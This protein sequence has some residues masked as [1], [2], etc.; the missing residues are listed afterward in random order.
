MLRFR[1]QRHL[2]ANKIRFGQQRV[3]RHAARAVLRFGL[4]MRMPVRVEHV[5]PKPVRRTAGQCGADPTQPDDADRLAL[6]VRAVKLRPDAALPVTGP[7]PLG[8]LHDTTRRRENEREHGIGG[9]LGQHIRCVRQ[10]DAPTRE[11]GHIEIVIADGDRRP[12]L[13]AG[14]VVEHL[15]RDL[16][17]RTDRTLGLCKRLGQ[18]LGT[19]NLHEFDMLAQLSRDIFGQRLVGN[20]KRFHQFIFQAQGGRACT[21]HAV[22][23]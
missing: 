20:D 18:R 17:A 10:H 21:H 11:I 3:E 2:Q 8:Q 9:R 14:R 23:A 12:R 6:D 1:R 16:Q 5:H 13:E 22:A 19:V 4:G 7:D 15:G